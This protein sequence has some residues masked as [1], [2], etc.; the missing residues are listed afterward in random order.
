MRMMSV[1]HA[2]F[3][4]GGGLT[5]ESESSREQARPIVRAGTPKPSSC[6]GVHLVPT[7]G[8]QFILQES[9]SCQN[10]FPRRNQ[11]AERHAIP[12]LGVIG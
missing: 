5:N 9:W 2:V 3:Q 1:Y 11:H 4:G 8:K 12:L 10:R 7:D 6:K